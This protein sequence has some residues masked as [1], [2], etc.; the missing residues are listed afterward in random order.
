MTALR[1]RPLEPYDPNFFHPPWAR[2]DPTTSPAIAWQD[3][4]R[5]S[6]GS[7]AGPSRAAINNIMIEVAK[8]TDRM[9]VPTGMPGDA[10]SYVEYYAMMAVHGRQNLTP[11]K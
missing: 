3:L 9:A 11:K 7:C 4:E 6:K 1:F 10:M 2:G 5:K 8:I